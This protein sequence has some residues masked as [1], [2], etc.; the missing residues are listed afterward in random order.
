MNIVHIVPGSGGGFYCQNC[1]RD[2]GLAK[3]MRQAGHDTMFV[4][5]YL[6]FME[7]PAD[8]G[9][10]QAPVFYGAIGVYLIQKFPALRRMPAFARRLLDAPVLLR[11]AARR[12]GTTA[13]GGLGELTLS[14]LRGRDGRQRD[15]LEQMIAWL[16]TQPAPDIVHFSNALLLGLAPALRET[17]G[18]RI[19]CS[20]Q[21]EETWL[22]ALDDPYRDA[23]W[24][25][26]REAARCVDLFLPVSAYYADKARE[27]LRLPDARFRILPLGVDTDDFAPAPAPPEAP[28]LG[29]LAP[30]KPW[31]GLDV[32]AQAFVELKRKPELARLRLRVA[33]GDPARRN[34][35]AK[36][37]RRIVSEAGFANDAEFL[38]AHRQPARGEFLRALTAFCL[39]AVQPEAGGMAPLEA[40]ACGVPVAL[41]RLGVYPEIVAETDGGVLFEHST[42]AELAA[43]L[44]PLLT[45]PALARRHGQAGR[46]AVERKRSLTI[47]SQAILNAYRDTERS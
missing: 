44:H 42:P 5:M 34:P 36:Q 20:L 41:P 7:T 1:V 29:F 3:T 11:R 28:T 15:E 8:A 31:S 25:A 19:V 16:K 18:A 38:D 40:M 32:V 17:L 9:I 6:P 23:C 47:M 21:D 33:G 30:W 46:T 24:A 2:I 45:D 43:A 22:D 39:P 26:V 35:F 14:V 4:P 10:A 12:A 13:A 27:F 37:C